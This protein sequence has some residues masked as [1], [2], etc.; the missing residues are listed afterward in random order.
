[1]RGIGTLVLALVLEAAL[2]LQLALPGFHESGA[3][4]VEMAR[5][6][7]PAPARAH[8]APAPGQPELCLDGKKC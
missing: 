7:R 6:A 1:M 2:L 5:A 4:A 3:A 8:P